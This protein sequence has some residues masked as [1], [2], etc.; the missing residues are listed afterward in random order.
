VPRLA[1]AVAVLATLVPAA[2]LAGLI[3]P[4][5]DLFK[6]PGNGSTY[7]SFDSN[8]IPA[9]FFGPGSDPFTGTVYFTGQPLAPT[10]A[11]GPTD[12]VVERTGGTT[13]VCGGPQVD[14][15]IEIVA[16][17]LVSVQPITVTYGGG[18]PELWDVRVG[19]SSLGPQVPGTMTL[20]QTDPIGGTFSATLPVQP[21]LVFTRI[22]PPGQQVLDG[23]P[24]IQFESQGYWTHQSPPELGICQS[25]GGVL[26]DHDANPETPE[27]PI[28]A[29][30]QFVAGIIKMPMSCDGGGGGFGKTLTAEE[31]LLAAHG[32]LPPQ[33]IVPPQE[34]AA[35]LGDKCIF[36]TP[37]QAAAMGAV[38]LGDGTMCLGDL[39]GNGRDDALPPGVPGA[40]PWAL[41][42]ALA[43]LLA[44][45]AWFLTRRRAG[46]TA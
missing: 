37:A 13:T 14:V 11:L 27:R 25:P 19:V 2:A 21:R 40:P 16:L 32:V 18:S 10:S 44:A 3:A 39:D 38:Y 30:S 22:G 17:S 45:G 41:L 29:S 43:L 7:Q 34:G 24:P 33:C 46:S 5:V 15:P 26:V 4:G 28:G 31:A 6:T 23:L 20:T 42:A 36:T 1:L 8:P 35:Q 12:T 9:D